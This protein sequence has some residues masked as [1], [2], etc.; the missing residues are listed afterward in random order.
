LISVI[1]GA[2]IILSTIRLLAKELEPQG[3]TAGILRALK[4]HLPFREFR[5]K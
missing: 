3:R 4:F 5:K 1:R 2:E